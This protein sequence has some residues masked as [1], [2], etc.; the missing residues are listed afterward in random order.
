MKISGKSSR[1]QQ[2]TS[3]VLAGSVAVVTRM[4]FFE[5]R[6][7]RLAIR[8]Y[9]GRYVDGFAVLHSIQTILSPK[10]ISR[11]NSKFSPSGIITRKFLA[12]VYVP[13]KSAA[14][15]LCAQYSSHLPDMKFLVSGVSESLAVSEGEGLRLYSA[16]ARK[17]VAT[18]TFARVLIVFMSLA[19]R[20]SS[21]R[22]TSLQSLRVDFS[23]A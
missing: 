22:L 5:L 15:L 10:R 8:E 3:G 13:P 19:A 14:T 17:F 12:Q 18:K 16:E 6:P 7:S 23:V 4:T 9:L 20:S 2:V 11:S 21:G 1:E